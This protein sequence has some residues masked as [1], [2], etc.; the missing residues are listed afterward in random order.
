MDSG[1]QI[2]VA[3]KVPLYL[4]HVFVVRSRTRLDTVSNFERAMNC[5]FKN[6]SRRQRVPHNHPG[7]FFCRR[8]AEDLRGGAGVGRG[9]VGTGVLE[10]H[11]IK[12]L[13]HREP[14][15]QSH[16][17][18]SPYCMQ[19][20]PKSENQASGRWCVAFVACRCGL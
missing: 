16:L 15:H 3:K 8:I 4:C 17:A 14:R 18:L 2:K 13:T 7:C 11:T 6:A 19:L 5:R 12:A 1:I 10:V 20:V 9:A